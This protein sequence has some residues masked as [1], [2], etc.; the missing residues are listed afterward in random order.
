MIQQNRGIVI[1]RQNTIVTLWSQS[2]MYAAKYTNGFINLCIYAYMY[3]TS[4]ETTLNG[5]VY[6]H[7]KYESFSQIYLRCTDYKLFSHVKRE[8]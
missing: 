1:L 2:F 3:K 4:D 6:V 5:T 7:M 8:L